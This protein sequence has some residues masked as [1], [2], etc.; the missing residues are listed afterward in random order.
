M[1]ERIPLRFKVMAGVVFLLA[2]PLT[3]FAFLLGG[4]A[5]G[6]AVILAI[7]LFYTGLYIVGVRKYI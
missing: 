2:G 5:A 4:P 6:A 7:M 3:L 1:F